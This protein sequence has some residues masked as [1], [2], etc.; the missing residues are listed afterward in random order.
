MQFFM[1]NKLNFIQLFI[2]I[3]FVGYF[4]VTRG[5]TTSEKLLTILSSNLIMHAITPTA[6]CFPSSKFK[7][8]VLCCMLYSV[9][10]QT[11]N[12]IFFLNKHL[13]FF[14][15]KIQREMNDYIILL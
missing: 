6:A 9:I 5:Q 4:E 13:V 1:F 12:V 14:L 7:N 3:I 2:E 10:I 8:N 15:S 11:F